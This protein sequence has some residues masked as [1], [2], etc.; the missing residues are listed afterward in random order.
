MRP[1][2]TVVLNEAGRREYERG[3]AIVRMGT[4]G[5]TDFRL[6]SGF[7]NFM[8][9]LMGDGKSENPKMS[10]ETAWQ[11]YLKDNDPERWDATK[12][13]EYDYRIKESQ[14]KPFKEAIITAAAGNN[15]R[16]VEYDANTHTW[17]DTGDELKLSDFADKKYTVTGTRMSS[18]GTQMI[19][20]DDSGKTYRL[21]MP[22]GINPVNENN[23]DEALKLAD[24]FREA[25]VKG[26]YNN[27][28]EYQQLLKDYNEA[29]QSAYLYNSQLGVTYD[30]KPEEFNPYVF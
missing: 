26:N 24:S 7:R 13:T 10:I 23:R 29:L 15:L 8:D 3:N 9:S 22:R 12:T 16:A 14:Q 1:D 19:V 30:T 20:Q 5:G 25:I 11:N 21:T 27:Q 4:A 28:A 17:K 6:D 2:G 18:S